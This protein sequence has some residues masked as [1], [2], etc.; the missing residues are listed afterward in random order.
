[1]IARTRKRVRAN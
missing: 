1:M